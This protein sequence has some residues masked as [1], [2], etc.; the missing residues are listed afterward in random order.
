MDA[1]GEEGGKGVA[2][3]G[4]EKDEGGDGVGQVVVCFD[5]CGIVR[6]GLCSGERQ[7][8]GAMAYVGYQGTI[9]SVIHA[10]VYE[11]KEDGC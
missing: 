3:E 4:G 6:W 5:L 9:G 8:L 7:G 1:V 11:G 2:D 10:E